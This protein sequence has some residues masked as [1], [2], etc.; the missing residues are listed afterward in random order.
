MVPF[1]EAVTDAEKHF[2]YRH[3][4]ARNCVERLNGVLKSVFRCLHG[5]LQCSPRRAGKIINA[6]CVLHNFRKMHGIADQIPIIDNEDSSDTP[7]EEILIQ[8][9][10]SRVA[11]ANT[12]RNNLAYNLI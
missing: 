8:N 4:A 12:I 10:R 6:C 5:E 11:Q 2:N 1:R 7:G 3:A 9:S